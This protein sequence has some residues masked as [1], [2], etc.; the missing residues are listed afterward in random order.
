M[1]VPT[2]LANNPI[3]PPLAPTMATYREISTQRYETEVGP[4]GTVPELAIPLDRDL[5]LQHHYY[6][7]KNT[8]HPVDFLRSFKLMTAQLFRARPVTLCDT[9]P[10]C[11]TA[12]LILHKGDALFNIFINGVAFRQAQVVE[13]SGFAQGH[14]IVQLAG[15][16]FDFLGGTTHIEVPREYVRLNL[17]DSLRYRIRQPLRIGNINPF[18]GRSPNSDL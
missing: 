5:D 11:L 18:Q 7:A 16:N 6:P 8:H 17:W 15:G 10:Y 9:C 4:R 13:I 12:D 3:D 1:T 14:V 2:T